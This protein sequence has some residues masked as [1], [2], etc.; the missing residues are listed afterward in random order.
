MHCNELEPNRN[1]NNIDDG[2]TAA[3]IQTH[4]HIAFEP[5]IINPLYAQIVY[6]SDYTCIW[7]LYEGGGDKGDGG[8]GGGGNCDR[9]VIALNIHA[10]NRLNILMR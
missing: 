9:P 8:G 6:I 4:T 5:I 1:E 10:I 2:E 7:L 3:K